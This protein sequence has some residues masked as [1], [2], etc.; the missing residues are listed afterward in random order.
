MK[1]LLLIL[2]AST[3]LL[4]ARAQYTDFPQFSDNWSV[5]VAGGVGHPL[6]YHPHPKLLTPSLGVGLKKQLTS[7]FSLGMDVDYVSWNNKLSLTRYERSQV[8][9]VGSLNLGNLFAGSVGQPRL[10]E[11]EVKGSAGWGH[12]FDKSRRTSPDANYLVSKWGIDLTYNFGSHRRWGLGLRPSVRFDL[13]N[14][15]AANYESFNA[16]RAELDIALGLTYR[17]G[18]KMV[19]PHKMVIPSPVQRTSVIYSSVPAV[20]EGSASPVVNGAM[21]PGVGKSTTA[22]SVPDELSLGENSTADPKTMHFFLKEMANRDET[23]ATQKQRIAELE[24]LLA[25]IVDHPQ[26][27]QIAASHR[28]TLAVKTAPAVVAKKATPQA[29]LKLETIVSFGFGR[30]VVDAPQFPN[31]ERVANYLKAHPRAKV[32]VRGYASPAGPLA[33]NIRMAKQRAESV[34][35]LLIAQYGIAENRIDADGNGVGN[36]FREAEWNSVAICSVYE[37]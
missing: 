10:F 28:D 5:T 35:N 9:V 26:S 29:S 1:R 19:V 30:V 2:L 34:M 23:I 12:I 25:K 33:T 17:F 18:N 3:P 14:D 27:T 20:L 31:V 21:E 7:S 36:F 13:R 32:K 15:G 37:D 6:I 24:M 4:G 22:M 11:V 16:N 8:H